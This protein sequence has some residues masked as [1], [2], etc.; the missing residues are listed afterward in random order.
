VPSSPP[1]G[2]RV[3]EGWLLDAVA[4]GVL[5]ALTWV[6]GVKGTAFTGLP[7]GADA[8]DHAGTVRVLLENFPH[9]LWN[10]AWFGGLPSVPGI[11]PPAY[12]LMIAAIVKGAGTSIEHAMVVSAAG[13]YFVMVASL[14]G[15]VRIFGRSRVAALLAGLVVLAVP[16]FWEPALQLGEYPRLTAAALGY[17]A[18][19]LAA[20]YTAK[21]TRLRLAGAVLLAGLAL[22]THPITGAVGALQVAAVLLLVPRWPLEVVLQRVGGAVVAMGGLAAWL[23][24]PSIIGS[25]AYY[26]VPQARLIPST[27]APFGSLLAPPGQSLAAF[28][29]LLVPLAA[30]LLTAVLWQIRRPRIG[31][32]RSAYDAWISRHRHL[33][34][35]VA[36]SAA[37]FLVALCLLG[38]A[39]VGH[40]AQAK[41]ELVGIYPDDMFSYAAW[42]LAAA[43]GVLLG[44]LLTMPR[45]QRAW[46][47]RLAAVAGPAAGAVACLVAM[48]PL[49]AQG[50]F[51][52]NA[53]VWAAAPKLPGATS[54]GQYRLALTDST[55]SSWSSFITRIPEIGGPFN[56]GALNLG[57]IT[58]V[59]DSLT[60]S[61]TPISEAKFLVQWSGLRWIEAGS[62]AGKYQYYERYPKVFE[63]LGASADTNYENFEVR[64]PSPVMAAT[65]APPVLAVGPF[66]DYEL[67]LQSLSLS[68]VGPGRLVPIEG[69]PYIDD[70]SLSE[71]ER[72]PVLV[73]YGFEAHDPR[74]AAQLLRAYVNAGGGIVAD[75]TADP[76]LAGQLAKYGA[77]LPVTSWATLRVDGRWRF[78]RFGHL[79]TKGID[80]A[81][82]SPALYAGVDPYQIEVARRRNAGSAVLLESEGR[83]VVVAERSGAGTVIEEG[84]NLPYHDDVYSNSTESAFLYRMITVALSRSWTQ[85]P[86]SARGVAMAADSDRITVAT[87]NGVLFK[88]TDAPDWH[89]TVDGQTA[90]IYPA[91]P[92]WM[93]VPLGPT[94]GT[95]RTV[96]FRYQLSL[97]EWGSIGISLATV[98]AL[99][100]FVVTPWDDLRL[101]RRLK[102]AMK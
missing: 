15:V 66:P 91:G 10:P 32:D 60:S 31:S 101:R 95:P 102:Q 96:E 6:I 90:P 39:F 20:L 89:A 76:L 25:S 59:E 24:V 73:L 81:R 46:R 17:L 23:Y 5:L 97:I 80:V 52:Y 56:Q 7:K 49:L 18:T 34:P 16:A 94:A 21:P 99:G 2:G 68:D 72:F 61:A 85:A 77:P 64:R 19:Y 4:V 35:V 92:G 37:F 36:A 53:I 98:L 69:A 40:L 22:G 51:S 67:F 84:L 70:Y 71:L 87:G 86:T 57:E 83:P 12:S 3:L 65:D 54:D 44:G 27:P 1:P 58:W 62:G 26:I 48:T 50:E 88:E 42:P 41:L 75:V 33:I 93:Y 45:M 63:P 43:T 82:F 8:L 30:V 47:W 11:Y 78:K 55:E 29:P 100:L 14:Y 79:L 74:K 28:S 13:A 38:Y 9:L